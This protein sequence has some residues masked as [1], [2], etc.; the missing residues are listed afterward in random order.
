MSELLKNPQILREIIMDHYQYPHNHELTNS[1]EYLS[2]HMASE[3][4]IDDIHVEAKIRDGKV[5]DVRFDGVACTIGTASTS[6]MTELMIGKTTEEART[7]IDEYYKMIDG[8]AYDEELLEEAVAFQNVGKQANR[9]K[10]AT[11]GWKAMEEMI[12]ES[13]SKNG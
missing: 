9:I 6:I 2:V 3:S 1:E 5:L 8:Q 4:C 7:I 10:C 12:A 13:E 11:I